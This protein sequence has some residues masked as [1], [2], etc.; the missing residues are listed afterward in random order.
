MMSLIMV[1]YRGESKHLSSLLLFAC[2]S[3]ERS[4][5]YEASVSSIS[6]SSMEAYLF[7]YLDHHRNASVSCVYRHHA[8]HRTRKSY[9]LKC[10]HRYTEARS[11]A[12]CCL[13]F[14][15]TPESSG[16]R[17]SV[18]KNCKLNKLKCTSNYARSKRCRRS[19]RFLRLK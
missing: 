16:I 17:G 18:A 12:D 13:L 4:V 9:V 7:V 3:I 5:P 6:P 11:L 1:D 10:W 2:S 15:D 14:T 19:A 8:H